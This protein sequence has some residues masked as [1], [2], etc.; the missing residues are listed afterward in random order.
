MTESG[1]PVL[2]GRA[3]AVSRDFAVRER[4]HLVAKAKAEK[5]AVAGEL[6]RRLAEV[7]ARYRSRVDEILKAAPRPQGPKY[8]AIGTVQRAADG[9][10]ELV[11]GGVTLH[12]IESLRYD[13]DE[14]VGLRVGVNGKEVK[15]DP[16][17]GLVLF[18]VDSLEILE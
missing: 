18:R 11:K 6:E 4:T 13:L 10:F 16:A 15:V 12:R 5:D 3:A 17:K 7:E 8:N 1:D 9:S 14:M 2:R